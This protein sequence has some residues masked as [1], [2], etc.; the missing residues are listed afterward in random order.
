[1]KVET[2]SKRYCS[3]HPSSLLPHPVRPQ[4]SQVVHCTWACHWEQIVNLWHPFSCSVMPLMFDALLPQE[5]IL[6]VGNR[7]I[8]M[9]I[10][11]LQGPK[12]KRTLCHKT[13]RAVQI[14]DTNYNL[15]RE[16]GVST[17]LVSAKLLEH[18]HRAIAMTQLRKSSHYFWVCLNTQ[19]YYL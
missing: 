8:V 6:F 19:F 18:R 1:M 7:C 9:W 10:Q 3:S 17:R 4:G 13:G 15:T 2:S 5:Q 12:Y 16:N 11:V 14:A